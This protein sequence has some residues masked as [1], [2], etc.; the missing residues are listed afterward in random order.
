MIVTCKECSTSFNLER[1]LIKPTGSKVRC[2]KCHSL[3]LVNL[4]VSEDVTEAVVSSLPSEQQ[5]PAGEADSFHRVKIPEVEG[6]PPMQFTETAGEEDRAV[7]ALVQGGA[8]VSPIFGKKGRK[9]PYRRGNTS[10]FAGGR[11]RLHTLPLRLAGRFRRTPGRGRIHGTNRPHDAS[12]VSFCRDS[13]P[14]VRATANGRGRFF[15]R[16]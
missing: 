11:A 12:R 3:F 14:Q 16:G 10:S 7:L 9:R 4:P 6:P 5:A 15:D 2:S 1:K 13:S 8:R